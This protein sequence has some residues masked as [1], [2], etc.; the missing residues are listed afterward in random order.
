VEGGG[1]KAAGGEDKIER[2]SDEQESSERHAVQN[3]LE[4]TRTRRINV[5]GKQDEKNLGCEPSKDKSG[6]RVAVC[7]GELNENYGEFFTAGRPCKLVL[8]KRR[9]GNRGGGLSDS[10]RNATRVVRIGGITERKSVLRTA[11]QEEKREAPIKKLWNAT[12]SKEE[13]EMKRRKRRAGGGGEVSSTR[14]Y[15]FSIW[16]GGEK[17]QNRRVRIN[18]RHGKTVASAN[19]RKKGLSH[20]IS[21]GYCNQGGLLRVGKTT[22]SLQ[23]PPFGAGIREKNRVR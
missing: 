22:G 10:R 3:D 1:A 16:G 17:E 2:P 18:E 8:K 13:K 15:S 21:G 14:W 7:R 12:R 4:V 23:G 19:H 6:G 20:R 5:L 11:L 9:R